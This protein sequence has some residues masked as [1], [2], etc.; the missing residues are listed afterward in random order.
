MLTS[1]T[2]LVLAIGSSL[3]GCLDGSSA[4]KEQPPVKPPT[5]R[6]PEPVEQKPEPVAK[7]IDLSLGEGFEMRRPIH[8]GK[9]TVIPIVATRALST[10]KFIT[11]HDGMARNL[12]HVRELGGRD[13]WDVDNVRIT[14]RSNETLVVLEGELIEDAMQDRVTAEATTI[15]A[16]ATKQVQVKCVEEDRDNGGTKF[17]P[18]HAFAELSLRRTLVH[19]N[20]DAIWSKVKVINAREKL[21]PRTNTYR[22]AAKAQLKG[23]NAARRDRIIKALDALEERPNVVG[24]AI[25]IDGQVMAVE[26]FGSPDLYKQYEAK[27]LASYLP[28]TAGQGRVEGKHLSPDEV[29]ALTKQTRVSRTEASLTVI[30]SL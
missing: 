12:V 9:L 19:S 4:P 24:F 5:P 17:N 6:A 1:R 13:S 21:Y 14:N 23:E 30:R 20:Q 27:L 22:H 7:K 25:A 26:R 11:L 29:R 10:Q 8:D 28:T 3:L 18:G 2:L 15:L 16:G